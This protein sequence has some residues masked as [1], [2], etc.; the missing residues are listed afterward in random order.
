MSLF[1]KTRQWLAAFSKTVATIFKNYLGSSENDTED[2][3]SRYNLNLRDRVL[4][5][6]YFRHN[7]S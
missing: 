3:L 7:F 4:K 2:G 6:I 5:L 1:W